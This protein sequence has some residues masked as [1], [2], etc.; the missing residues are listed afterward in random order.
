MRKGVESERFAGLG[1]STNLL[2]YG[3]SIFSNG[4]EMERDG[5]SGRCGDAVREGISPGV[6][7]AFDILLMGV[8]ASSTPNVRITE[9]DI[10]IGDMVPGV[11]G[12]VWVLLAMSSV[13]GSSVLSGRVDTSRV[14]SCPTLSRDIETVVVIE[15]ERDGGNS[16]AGGRDCSPILPRPQVLLPGNGGSHGLLAGSFPCVSVKPSRAFERSLSQFRREFSRVQDRLGLRRSSR[17]FV[18]DACV[19]R[20]ERRDEPF[21]CRREAS[22]RMGSSISRHDKESKRTTMRRRRGTESSLWEST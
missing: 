17:S 1:R 13:L 14:E 11:K 5:G 12:G 18:F 2:Q 19:M 4:L 7:W 8:A 3:I 6:S 21:L 9:D 16:S 10:S 22:A 20:L 15:A